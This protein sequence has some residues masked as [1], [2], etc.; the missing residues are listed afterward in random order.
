M[1]DPKAGGC[2]L[3]Y[4]NIQVIKVWTYRLIVVATTSATPIR[5]EARDENLCDGKEKK[6]I[7]PK[8]C[9]KCTRNDTLTVKMLPKHIY[10]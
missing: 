4:L 6:Y 2:W 5:L 10:S 7:G 1:V 9:T 3:A 8:I